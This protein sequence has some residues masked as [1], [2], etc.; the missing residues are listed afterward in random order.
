MFGVQIQEKKD[1]PITIETEK[2]ISN[3][4]INLIMHS[5]PFRDADIEYINTSNPGE[6]KILTGLDTALIQNFTNLKWKNLFEFEIKSI[7]TSNELDE[8]NPYAF[9]SKN[10]LIE[11]E[12][13]ARLKKMKRNKHKRYSSEY[14]FEIDEDEDYE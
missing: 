12:T 9:F 3:R 8:D 7:K 13:L 1:I 5:E 14:L 2:V 6:K 11:S 4:D 10:P